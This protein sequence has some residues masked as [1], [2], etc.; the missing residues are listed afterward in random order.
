MW[1]GL[2]FLVSSLKG[3]HSISINFYSEY[4]II[5][6]TLRDHRLNFFLF[7]TNVE[8]KILQFLNKTLLLWNWGLPVLLIN[9]LK[10]FPC[11]IEPLVSYLTVLELIKLKDLGQ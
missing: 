3:K 8:C 7:T 2:L 6:L 1:S 10:L 9:T 11:I 5:Q 4:W